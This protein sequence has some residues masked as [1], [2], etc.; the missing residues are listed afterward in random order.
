MV[1]F[2]AT[3][4]ALIGS[5]ICHDLISPIGAISNGLELMGLSGQMNGPEFELINDSAIN[6]GARIRFFRIA[7]GVA[8]EQMLGRPEVLSVLADMNK[9]G[10]VRLLWMPPDAQ[11][12]AEVR[13]A[14]LAMQCCETALPFGGQAQVT[15]DSGHWTVTG[16]GEKLA[17][18]VGLWPHLHG[19]GEAED[20]TPSTV[21]FAL[22]P[23]IAADMGRKIAVAHDAGRV[24]ISF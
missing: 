22:L 17:P 1:D 7:Y 16:T 8:G 15:V 20:I 10:R 23:Q 2:N 11:P 13:L 19:E 9:A 21:Q 4:G 18:L 3:L 5:R 12:R 14:F 6:A 24:A